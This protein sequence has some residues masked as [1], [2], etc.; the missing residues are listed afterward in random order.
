M[1]NYDTA[2]ANLVTTRNHSRDQM[3][4]DLWK[5]ITENDAELWHCSSQPSDN[6]QPLRDQ[7]M[8]DLWK[9]IMEEMI[10]N[11]DAALANLV[12]TRSHSR[13]HMMIDLWKSITAKW[14]RTMTLLQPNLVTTRNTPETRWW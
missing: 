2:P 6:T 3:M 8:L 9:S 4:I 7:I 1:Q 11:Y 5:S 13:D 14:C 10:Q 12:T